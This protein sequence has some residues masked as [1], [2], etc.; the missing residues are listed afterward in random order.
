HLPEEEGEQQGADVAA[1]DVRVAH[2]D[3]LVVAALVDVELLADAGAD[4]RDEG[5]DLGVLEH[6]VEAG[7]LDVEDLAPD[8]EDGLGGGVAGVDGGAAGRVALDDE[9]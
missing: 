1:V 8:R 3:D 7:P 4:G 6:L 2:A 5:L 9:Q